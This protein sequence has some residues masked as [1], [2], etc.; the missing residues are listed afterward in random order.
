MS[1]PGIDHMVPCGT[2]AKPT[3]ALDASFVPDRDFWRYLFAGLSLLVTQRS[4]Q[5]GFMDPSH[6]VKQ[7]DALLEEL[8]KE[9]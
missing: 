1:K 9:G 3:M 8:E 2:A 4:S 5:H 6:A 7:A